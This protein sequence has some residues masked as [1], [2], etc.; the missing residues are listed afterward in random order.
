MLKVNKIFIEISKFFMEVTLSCLRISKANLKWVYF[1]WF[2]SFNIKKN[3]N[4][5]FHLTLLALQLISKHLK[6]FLLKFFLAHK[7]WKRSTILSV[8]HKLQFQSLYTLPY[9]IGLQLKIGIFLIKL[10]ICIIFS[11]ELSLQFINFEFEL[12]PYSIALLF[13][14]QLD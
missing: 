11:L 3:V 1:P 7:I 13:R 8:F 4:L 14:L 2:F 10:S 5:R 6:F 9:L 12:S